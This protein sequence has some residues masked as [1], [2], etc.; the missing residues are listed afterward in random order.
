[1]FH[2]EVDIVDTPPPPQSLATSNYTM[3]Q[4][5]PKPLTMAVHLKTTPHAYPPSPNPSGQSAAL[6]CSIPFC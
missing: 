1:M 3:Q 6:P 2:K 4:W 5:K